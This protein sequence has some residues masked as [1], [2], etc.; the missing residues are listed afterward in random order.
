LQTTTT[1][2]TYINNLTINLRGNN[3]SDFRIYS[4]A[5]SA[6]DI[7][8]LYQVSTKIDNLNNLHCYEL[9]ENNVNSINKTG[10]VNSNFGERNTNVTIYKHV[11][12]NLLQGTIIDNLRYERTSG[13]GT[14]F[15]KRFIPIQQLETNVNYT[16]SA[17]IRG[18]ANMNLYTINTG[19]N[20]AFTYANKTDMDTEEF[21]LFSVTF[22]VTGDRTIQ[23]I[24]PCSRYGEANTAVGD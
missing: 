15:G 16:F 24:Y 3:L 22:K 13:M 10:I 23:E 21:K 4:T 9:L 12:P 1:S 2:Q 11:N 7:K 6:D 20:M 14:E 17:M 8:Q 19:G 18:S 5:L